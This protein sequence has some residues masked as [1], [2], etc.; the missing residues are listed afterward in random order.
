MTCNADAECDSAYFFQEHSLPC[1]ANN[2]KK[3]EVFMFTLNV[4]L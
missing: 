3:N 4:Y 2:E 1:T